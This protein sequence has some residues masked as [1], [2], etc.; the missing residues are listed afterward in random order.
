MQSGAIGDNDITASSAYDSASVGPQHGRHVF[1]I[2]IFKNV[3]KFTFIL[4]CTFAWIK[5]ILLKRASIYQ[6]LYNLSFSL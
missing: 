5:L 2:L 3:I 1:K 6:V 4:K